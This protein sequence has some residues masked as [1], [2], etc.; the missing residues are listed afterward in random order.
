MLSRS[1]PAMVTL[2][3]ITEE[4]WLE[5]IALGVRPEQEKQL[6]LSFPGVHRP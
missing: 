4:N 5:V 2:R 6:R 3:E 1:K